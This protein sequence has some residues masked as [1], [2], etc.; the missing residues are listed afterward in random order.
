MI[1]LLSHDADASTAVMLNPRKE[2]EKGKPLLQIVKVYAN[3]MLVSCDLLVVMMPC[4]HA[5][6]CQ[7]K[8]EAAYSPG[9]LANTYK[10]TQCYNP[11]GRNIR[12]KFVIFE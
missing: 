6:G 1:L 4:S 9:I 3:V 7:V 11:E 8:M 12:L 2:R 5:D 10:A